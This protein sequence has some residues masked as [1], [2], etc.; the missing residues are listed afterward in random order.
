M[1]LASASDLE[2][3]LAPALDQFERGETDQDRRTGLIAIAQACDRLLE[4]GYTL[5]T[6]I[7]EA[8][9]AADLERFRARSRAEGTRIAQ[10]GDTAA[11]AAL[12]RL[13]TLVANLF[14]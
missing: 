2:W 9:K 14:E 6:E 8:V 7:A 1:S 4:Q 10:P 3:F 13:A 5:P 11:E 12:R